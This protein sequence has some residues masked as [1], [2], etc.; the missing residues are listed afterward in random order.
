[1]NKYKLDLTWRESHSLRFMFLGCA[2][3][4]GLFGLQTPGEYSLESSIFFIL[5]FSCVF[6]IC[7]RLFGETWFIIPLV[8][9]NNDNKSYLKPLKTK[10]EIRKAYMSNNDLFLYKYDVIFLNTTKQNKD[11]IYKSIEDYISNKIAENFKDSP[12]IDW[13]N[14]LKERKRFYYELDDVEVAKIINGNNNAKKQRED[15]IIKSNHE[16]VIK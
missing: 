16:C 12:Y 5:F 4:T 7:I 10:E 15:Y 8:W 3:L 14:T 1:M 11:F 6:G 2:L 13:C 9:T